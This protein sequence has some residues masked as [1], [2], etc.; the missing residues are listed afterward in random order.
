M[1]QKRFTVTTLGVIVPTLFLLPSV[2]QAQYLDP[3]AGSIM[4]QVVIAALVGASA[5]VKIYWSRISAFLARR[6]AKR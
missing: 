3:G 6:K 4:V 1:Q 5:T 2:A